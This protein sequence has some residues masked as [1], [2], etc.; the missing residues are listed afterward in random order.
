LIHWNASS[1]LIALR[2]KHHFAVVVITEDEINAAVM[3]T[4]RRKIRAIWQKIPRR[5]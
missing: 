3:K 1:D 4:I 2:L 5:W